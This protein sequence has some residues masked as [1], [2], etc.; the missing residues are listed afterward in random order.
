M[1]KDDGEEKDEVVAVVMLAI[2]GCGEDPPVT[3]ARRRVVADWE[4]TKARVTRQCESS[5]ADVAIANAAF[6]RN[7][8]CS[9]LLT[10][11]VLDG[12]A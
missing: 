12:F 4:V 10:A 2:E 5:T 1:L 6:M 11:F 8:F 3:N 7:C 9:W